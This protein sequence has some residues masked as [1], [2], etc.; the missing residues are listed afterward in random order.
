[1]KAT[2]NRPPSCPLYKY[3]KALEEKD[4][5]PSISWQLRYAVGEGEFPSKAL[6]GKTEKAPSL[7][8]SSYSQLILTSDRNSSTYSLKKAVCGKECIPGGW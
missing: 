5:H 3:I 4:I 7:P 2:I 6:M 8:F 1:M